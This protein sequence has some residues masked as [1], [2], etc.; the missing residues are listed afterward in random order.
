[1]L[2]MILMEKRYKQQWMF[3]FGQKKLLNIREI[4]E[5]RLLILKVV[6]YTLH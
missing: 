2:D 6:K 3:T 1:M 4:Q 5:R